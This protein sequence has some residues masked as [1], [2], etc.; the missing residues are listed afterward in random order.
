MVVSFDYVLTDQLRIA[1]MGDKVLE[2]IGGGSTA[3]PPALE[4]SIRPQGLP[5]GVWQFLLEQLG[6]DNAKR[7]VQ[8]LM[9]W[10]E[11]AVSG[12]LDGTTLTLT[13]RA[14]RR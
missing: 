7:G 4:L 10:S 13:A 1:A 2:T 3:A 12:Q 6:V 9:L 11:L 8:R 14:A 5:A